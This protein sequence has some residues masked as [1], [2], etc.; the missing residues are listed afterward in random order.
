M[1]VAGTIA[2]TREDRWSVA[3]WAFHWVVQHLIDHVDDADAVRR[4]QE[5][6]EYNLGWWD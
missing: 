3:S 5:I 1:T 4:L 2:I 6:E